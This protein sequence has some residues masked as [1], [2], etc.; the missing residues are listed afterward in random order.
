MVFSSFAFLCFFLSGVL[1]LHTALPGVRAKNALLIL[2]SLVFYAYG[3]Q[4]YIV[5]MLASVV[6]NYALGLLVGRKKSRSV[7]ALAVTVNLAMLFVFKYAGFFAGVINSVL[8]A[9]LAIPAP[10]IRLPIGISFYTFQALS[11]VVDVYRGDAEEQ[12][13]LPRM[14]LYISFFPQLIAGPIIRYHDVAQQIGDRRVTAEG[15]K[16]GS[17]RFLCGLGKKILISNA[18]ALAADTVF[19]LAND[20]VGTLAAWVGALSYLMQIYFDFSGYSDMAIGLGHMFGFT[21]AENFD[22]PYVSVSIQDFWRRWHISLSTWFREYLYIPLGGNRHGKAK[23]LRNRY[24]VFLMTGLWHGA[25]WTFILWG[26]YHGTLLVLESVNAI[27]VYRN[28]E[29]KRHG[30]VRKA[31]SHVYVL[32]AVTF[33]FVLFRAGTLPQAGAFFAAM[34]GFGASGGIGYATAAAFLSPYY[35]FIFIIAIIGS[36][37]YPARLWRRLTERFELFEAAAMA[38][39]LVLLALSYMSL[40]SD[41]YNPFIYFRF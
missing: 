21:F 26:L 12:K 36:T 2:G 23:T 14:L 15:M 39:G 5:L 1:V 9:G 35:L 20:E 19:A 30:K 40:A 41:S 24:I 34:F 29:E 27:P 22:H 11:Y 32:L 31:L 8:P 17:L 6:M 37:P 4:I 13:S 7:L 16:K 10:E 38:G 18:M 3:E 33:G 25:N 28:G